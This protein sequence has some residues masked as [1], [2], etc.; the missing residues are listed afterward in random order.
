MMVSFLLKGL[1]REVEYQINLRSTSTCVKPKIDIHIYHTIF[2]K[3]TLIKVHNVG[4]LYTVS[5]LGQPYS[6]SYGV[7]RHA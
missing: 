4:K 3:S 2:K 1:Y 5:Y 7:F 6:G